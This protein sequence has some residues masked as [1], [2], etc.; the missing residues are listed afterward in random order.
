MLKKPVFLALLLAFALALTGCSG[1]GDWTGD[2]AD[3]GDLS[4]FVTLGAYTGIAVPAADIAVSDE[5]LQAE[6]D[7]MLSAY[8]SE[9]PVTD[10]PLALGDTATIDYV[11]RMD[12]E[13]FEGGSAEGQPLTL[14][15]GT[16]IPGFEDQL[17]GVAIGETKVV[18][19]N[20]PDPYA[21]NPDF[22]GKPA[23]FTVTV[24]AITETITPE[25]TDE[26]AA[27]YL[28]GQSAQGYRSSLAESMSL[29]LKQTAVWDALVAST[30][31][32]AYP[33]G[34][35]DEL[36]VLM[37]QFERMNYESAAQSYGID[38]ED[39]LNMLGTEEER[40]V[41]YAE[42]AERVATEILIYEAIIR[43]ENI[44]VTEAEVNAFAESRLA[45]SGYDT[46]EAYIEAYE[47]RAIE[48]EVQ[49][50]KAVD[51]IMESAVVS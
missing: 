40:A 44:T 27:E 36:T 41:R 43:A 17:V 42:E 32:I 23:E 50:G 29:T 19:V 35:L 2:P 33:D 5:A 18:E 3:I 7:Y 39:L 49:I 31:I 21:N 15:S 11:G 48:N 24:H 6:I 9:Q 47:Y 38:V 37:E 46:A 20:F 22:S 45:E 4:D 34:M 14:G 51:L 16:F 28:G 12:G 8:T 10:R 25:L 26:F 30:T 13:I 1:G